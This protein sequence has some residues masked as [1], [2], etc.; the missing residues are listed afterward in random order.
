MRNFERHAKILSMLQSHEHASI[1]A[2]AAACNTTAQTIRRDLKELAQAGLLKRFHGGAM[3]A[4]ATPVAISY[5][6]KRNLPQKELVASLVPDLIPNDSSIFLSGGSTL[7]FAA[8][9]LRRRDGLTIVTNNL[10]AAVALF[11]RK[12]FELHVVG[13]L[14]RIASGS[15]TGERAVDFIGRFKV[16]I[17]V[18]GTSG[19]DADGTLLEYDHSIV[20]SMRA[21]ISNSRKKILVADSSKF[22]G[23]GVVRGAHISE[24]DIFVCDR[25]P[26]AIMMELLSAGGV[27]LHLPK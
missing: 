4:D 15:I 24:F 17:A 18:L 16:D 7:A 25:K 22:Q 9:G 26:P 10:H 11:D 12:G 13:G 5:D 19:I 6:A 20:S 23:G 3:L 2:L 8:E 21:M 1:D 27:A 14:S